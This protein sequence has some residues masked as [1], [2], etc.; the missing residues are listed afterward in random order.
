MYLH[1]YVYA[2]LRKDGTPYYIGKGFENRAYTQH[3]TKKGGVH[4]P[5]DKSRIVFLE[6]NLTEVGAFAFERRYIKWYGRQDIGTGILKN[7]TDGGEGASG[8]VRSFL[9][10]QQSIIF[11]A[12]AK[13]RNI[14]LSA[15]G[16]HPF[17]NP[18]WITKEDRSDRSKNTAK[19][20]K[21]NN[22]LG[23]QLGHAST[24]GSIGGKI[25]GAISGRLNKG[26][27]GVIYKNGNTKRISVDAYN[28]Y[29][30]LMTQNKI[31]MSEWEFVT[32]RSKESKNRLQIG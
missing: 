27:I 23:F 10:K 32:V 2:Y 31:P 25:G 22:R 6:R 12:K 11:G 20:Q 4:T 13:Q 21:E 16:K 18:C 8:A 17:Q 9:Q 19:K 30:I 15:N 3:R 14:N 24:A 28:Q 29:K 5:K 1:F 26:S 7:R